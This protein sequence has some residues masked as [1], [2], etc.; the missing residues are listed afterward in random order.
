MLAFQSGNFSW[1]YSLLKEASRQ[2]ADN[3][4]V[5]HD[6]AWAAYSLGK[7]RDAREAMNR[8]LEISASGSD[9]DD[10]RAFLALVPDDNGAIRTG[11]LDDA[12]AKRLEQDT[13]Y[14]P[15]LMI[16][17]SNLSRGGNAKQA[18]ST[19]LRVLERFPDFAPAQKALAREYA[20]DPEKL[21]Q[22]YDLATKARQTLVDDPELAGVLAQIAYF[23][24]EYPR[25]VQLLQ[26]SARRKSLESTGLYYLGMSQFQAN[27]KDPARD[28]LKKAIAAGL[29]EPMLAEAK[30]V[31]SGLEKQ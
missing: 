16:Q 11:T 23:R 20:D 14:I 10:A 29:R 12:V 21:G 1:A 15:A 30:R 27:Q 19:L 18:E 8:S 5:Q 28:A 17:A 4:T 3:A 7:V 31:L 13:N 9:A 22:A 2:Q 25:A 24:K 26:E 6:Y